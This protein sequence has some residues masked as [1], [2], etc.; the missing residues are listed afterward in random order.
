MRMD[1]LVRLPDHDWVVAEKHKLIPSVYAVIEIQPK[2]WGTSELSPIPV[3]QSLQ[4][5]VGSTAEALLIPMPRIL[6]G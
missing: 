3:Q 5:E 4:F 2:K 1:Y 6:K